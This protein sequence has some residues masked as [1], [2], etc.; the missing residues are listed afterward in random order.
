M[1]KLA[2]RIL[3]ALLFL[4]AP[5][6]SSDSLRAAQSI[7]TTQ[8]TLVIDPGHGGS[9]TGIAASSGPNE[10]EATLALAKQIAR[11]LDNRYN[12]RLTR[13]EDIQIPPAER[14]AHANQNRADFFLSLHLHGRKIGPGMIFYFDNPGGSRSSQPDS[15]RDQPLILQA[16]SRKAAAVLSNALSGQAIKV[17]VVPAPAPVLE[18]TLMPALVMEPFSLSI[19]AA[20]ENREAVLTRFSEAISRGID[21]ILKTLPSNP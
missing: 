21:R 5:G 1:T 10:K 12:V 17:S 6:I 8:K 3:M 18:G 15:W 20:P 19:L 9:D 7:R 16:E 11:L 4:A 14:A 2:L 13:T